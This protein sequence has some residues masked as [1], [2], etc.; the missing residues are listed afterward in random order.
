MTATTPTAEPAIPEPAVEPTLK[1][2][3]IRGSVQT[4]LFYGSSQALRLASNL[5]LTRLLTD[6]PEAFAAMALCFVWLEGIELFSDVGI[7]P[8][9]VQSKHGDDQTFLDTAWTIQVARGLAIWLVTLLLTPV[10]VWTYGKYPETAAMMPVI[11]LAAV[12]SGFYSTKVFTAMRAMRPLQAAAV[13]LGG[14]VATTATMIG[15]AWATGS[16]WA[17]VAGALVNPL[18]QVLIGH[19]ALP[20]PVNRFRFVKEHARA[21]FRYGRWVF[22]STMFTFLARQTDRLVLPALISKYAFGVYN[23]ALVGLAMCVEVVSHVVEWVAFPAF[24]RKHNAGEPVGDVFQRVTLILQLGAGAMVAGL[25]AGGPALVEF[26]YDDRYVAAGWMLR[27]LGFG[28][29][30][31][32]LESCCASLLKAVAANQWMAAGHGT[33]FG[34]QLVAMPLGYWLGG[35]DGALGAIVVADV[36]RFLVASWGIERLGY[37]FVWRSV[38]LTALLVASVGLGLWEEAHLDRH[39][40][41]FVRAALIGG[42]AALPWVAAAGVVLLRA[43]RL[44]RRAE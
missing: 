43:R 37:A 20:G 18:V 10:L 34:V 13:Q 9:I 7:R 29:W 44:A 8:A 3:V 4:L 21:L 12:V 35:L 31:T 16:V 24:A 5:V 32:V 15:V 41:A 2:K 40:P 28:A 22:V 36:A 6:G 33:K 38:G 1:K 23:I 14:Q 42:A 25:I 17:L 30:F 39:L 27:L 19:F 11:G 26:L